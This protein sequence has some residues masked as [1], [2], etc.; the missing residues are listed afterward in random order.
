MLLDIH[1]HDPTQMY[2]LQ[3]DQIH[4]PLAF[5]DFSAELN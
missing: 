1:H 3:H 4:E 2:F 5:D